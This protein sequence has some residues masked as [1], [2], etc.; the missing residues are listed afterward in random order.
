MRRI[1]LLVFL[2]LCARDGSS[3][4]SHSRTWFLGKEFLACHESIYLSCSQFAESVRLLG[5]ARVETKS[6]ALAGTWEVSGGGRLRIG[7]RQF[8]FSEEFGLFISSESDAI[9]FGMALVE[10]TR[11]GRKRLSEREAHLQEPKMLREVAHLLLQRGSQV[12]DACITLIDVGDTSSV[13]LLVAAFPRR[14]EKPEP[15]VICTW[16]HCAEALQRIT[17]KKCGFYREDWEEC[18]GKRPA[19]N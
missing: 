10:D 8:Q 1:P 16:G 9:R 15:G 2:L 5:D 19:P 18:I 12:H 17:G 7:Q 13:D 11:T 14:P 6:E 4:E 3:A